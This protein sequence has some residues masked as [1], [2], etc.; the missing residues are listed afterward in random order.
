LDN[1]QKMHHGK[2]RGYFL[3]VGDIKSNEWT[4]ES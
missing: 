2:S 4:N 3:I 1:A